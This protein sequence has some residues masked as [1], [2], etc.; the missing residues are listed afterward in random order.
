MDNDLQLLTFLFSFLFGIVFFYLLKLNYFF[1]SKN[2]TFIQYIDNT[3]F[4]LNMVLLYTIINFK[5]NDG[6]FHP[7]FIFTIILGYIFANFTQK[8]VKSTLY[9]LKIK[10]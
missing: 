1:T 7:Y 4:I 6:Y 9:K 8:Y 2:H 5:I 3:L 10:K